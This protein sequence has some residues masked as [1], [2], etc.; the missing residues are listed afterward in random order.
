MGR[1]YTKMGLTGLQAEVKHLQL[2]RSEGM[3]SEGSAQCSPIH[4]DLGKQMQTA[5]Q[6]KGIQPATSEGMVK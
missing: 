6:M 2:A 5:I 3:Q 4:S 1:T